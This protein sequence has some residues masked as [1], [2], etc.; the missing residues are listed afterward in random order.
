M[1]THDEILAIEDDDRLV[2]AAFAFDGTPL[3]PLVRFG[4]LLGLQRRCLGTPAPD[5][6]LAPRRERLRGAAQTLA[7]SAWGAP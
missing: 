7:A 6:P 3:W 4:V 1:N 5:A 2:D